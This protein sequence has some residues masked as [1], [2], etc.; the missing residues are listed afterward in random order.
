MNK[1]QKHVACSF[2]CKLVY[3][4]DKFGKPFKSYVGKN[5]VYNFI[6]SMTEESK[7]CSDVMKKHFNKELVITKENNENFE[8]FT[9]CWIC[10]NVYSEGDVKVR[11]HFH[12]ME[13]CRGSA[14][15]DCNTR[16][17]LYQKITIIFHNWK[18]CESHLIMQELGKFY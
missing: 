12:M 18:N 1:Y 4:D 10:D 2:D 14:H 11:D 8:N 3:D 13:K 17:L 7:Y 15:R 9:K 5:A 6:N 16:I